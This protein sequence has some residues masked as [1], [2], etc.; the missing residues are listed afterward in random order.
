MNNIVKRFLIAQEVTQS[1]TVIEAKFLEE[2]RFAH[3]ETKQHGLL[4]IEGIDGG[5]IDAVVSL[6]NTLCIASHQD[7]ARQLTLGDKLNIGTNR[8]E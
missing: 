1:N 8:A 7:C 6:T 4:A 5:D 3:I 2:F